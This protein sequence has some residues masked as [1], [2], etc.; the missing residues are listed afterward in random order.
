MATA[1]SAPD[2]ARKGIFFL[3][4]ALCFTPWA[5]PPFALA[6]G[7]L[8]A[9]SLGNPYPKESKKYSG[10]LLRFAVVLLGFSMDLGV[11]LRAGAQ[12]FMFAA[13]TITTTLLLGWAV[14][15]LLKIHKYTSSLIS[16]GT[17][18]CGGSAIA[19]VGSVVRAPDAEMS[20]ALG[21]VFILNAVALFLFPVIGHALALTQSQFGTWAGVAI[22]DISSV[23]GAA[24]QYG[25]TALETATAVK[26]SRALWII[27]LALGAAVIY[28]R[29]GDHE[30][31][32]KPKLQIPWFIGLFLLASLIR[33]NVHFVA[34]MEPYIKYA[35]GAGL[36]LTLFLIGAGLSLDAIKKVGWRPMAQGVFLW[37]F[38]S[39]VSLVVITRVA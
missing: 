16:S 22:H 30:E 31:G 29:S 19:A 27:P 38:I 3:L 9:V 32:A 33:S 4:S 26:L 6:A 23:V 18:I 5:Q 7:L 2:W 1:L 12:G 17:A 20:V 28:H 15:R 36:G 24:K 25:L 37:A 11:V 34:K 35:A 14:G 21:T 8:F 13:A 10:P 39:V